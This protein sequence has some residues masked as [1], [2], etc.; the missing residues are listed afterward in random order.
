MNTCYKIAL[1]NVKEVNILKS[2]IRDY[3]SLVI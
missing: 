2:I 1:M 3:Y